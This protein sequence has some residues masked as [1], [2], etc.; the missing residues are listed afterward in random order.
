M[1]LEIKSEFVKPT[2]MRRNDGVNLSFTS[3]Q[4]FS[5]RAPSPR[6]RSPYEAPGNL[7]RTAPLCS[8]R[9]AAPENETEQQKLVRLARSIQMEI[10][11]LNS[12]VVPL[13][14]RLRKHETGMDNK[15]KKE[16][17]NREFL[18]ADLSKYETQ[19]QKAQKVVN[20]QAEFSDLV[21]MHSELQ[22]RFTRSE[23]GKLAVEL[24][25]ERR[26]WLAQIGICIEMDRKIQ[27][28]KR[29]IA[30]LMKNEDIR[31]VKEQEVQI[32]ELRAAIIENIS[33]HRR[34]KAEY[35]KLKGDEPELRERGV[36]SPGA[37]SRLKSRLQGA[38]N[39]RDNA[40]SRYREVLE[41]QRAELEQFKSE[42][43]Q[44]YERDLVQE[45]EI[46]MLK[47]QQ[48]E[49]DKSKRKT[50]PRRQVR[51]QY[52]PEMSKKTVWIGT[53]DY[54]VAM[55]TVAEMCAGC[56]TIQDVEIVRDDTALR[57]IGFAAI[58][59]FGT[60]RSA[61][62]A[63]VNLNGAWFENQ[64]LVAEWYEPLKNVY[65]VETEEDNAKKKQTSARASA[66]TIERSEKTVCE[67]EPKR[68]CRSE[69]DHGIEESKEKSEAA[70]SELVSEKHEEI[71][72]THKSDAEEEHKERVSAF[73]DD[74]FL[75][76]NASAKETRERDLSGENKENSDVEHPKLSH[77]EE[78]EKR[79]EHESGKESSK[80]S[81]SSD[82]FE[83]LDDD[84]L[85]KDEDEEKREAS[86]RNV[87]EHDKHES[88]EE[89]KDKEKSSSSSSDLKFGDLDEEF[90]DSSSS[91][92]KN[93]ENKD[94]EKLT[95]FT[96][97]MEGKSSDPEKDKEPETE[98]LKL[99]D[100]ELNLKSGEDEGE[101]KA[102]EIPEETKLSDVQMDIADAMTM[103][104]KV[105]EEEKETKET[106][107]DKE[108]K[109][110]SSSMNFDFDND[111]DSGNDKKKSSSDKKSFSGSEK[112][113][114]HKKKSSSS[115]SSDSE[116]S[117]KAE[118]KSSGGWDEDFEQKSE[119]EGKNDLKVPDVQLNVADSI[120][121][122]LDE[123]REDNEVKERTFEQMES[124]AEKSE[125]KLSSTSSSSSAEDEKQNEEKGLELS[126]IQLE[127]P[128]A[129]FSN[130]GDGE[131]KEPESDHLVR[132]RSA[133][134][135]KENSEV[136]KEEKKD[137][138]SAKGSSSSSS[139][140]HV[141]DDD[142]AEKNLEENAEKKSEAGKEDL[143]LPDVQLNVVDSFVAN[144]DEPK[145]D[146][147]V[148]ERAIEEKTPNTDGIA[149]VEQKNESEHEKKVSSSG[150]KSSSSSDSEMPVKET[151]KVE[152]DPDLKLPDIQLNVAHSVMANLEE[153]KD[154]EVNEGPHEVKD[155]GLEEEKKVS[156]TEK[157][158]EI[159]KKED[160]A[161]E[162]KP[163][164]SRK[165]SSSS[166]SSEIVTTILGSDSPKEEN[167]RPQEEV[168]TKSEPEEKND[169]KL[170]DIQL[171]IADSVVANLEE[172]K[173]DEEN[174]E[175]KSR[176]LEEEKEASEAEKQ[177][178]IEKK[179]ASDNEKKPSSSRKVS[180]SSSEDFLKADIIDSDSA[181]ENER[182]QK[183]EVITKSEPEEKNDLKLPDIQLNV[184]DSIVANF[185]KKKEEEVKSRTVEES[186]K[187]PEKDPPPKE[188]SS[189]SSDHG[190]KSSSS[191]SS[192]SEA[193][194]KES[195]V[196]SDGANKSSGGW[197]EDFDN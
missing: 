113:E 179:E 183:E 60:H 160:S 196:K 92:E 98:G 119:S 197:D 190:K 125:K 8:T 84:F 149:E 172:K 102:R 40:E 140:D 48:K 194:D 141:L 68:K 79:S 7:V 81:S 195:K 170:P 148:K 174:A 142:E 6:R 17:L 188:A 3:Y 23:I 58:V 96:L 129:M 178:E 189:K 93:E 111:F 122:N 67:P 47:E 20:K 153:K 29:R 166:S 167:E 15:Q 41:S 90:A 107:S 49:L 54:R 133:E 118:K 169:L 151:K 78:E 184:A 176:G 42:Q 177:P 168:I 94:S 154:D 64:R 157:Q 1:T 2:L 123:G 52:N 115:S 128:D 36:E 171:N 106:M 31:A 28:R 66:R 180:S 110:S 55:S 12:E 109:K 83:D 132:D 72:D 75:D 159:E 191:S 5:P 127:S 10:N 193:H 164:S 112:S 46:R 137:S 175:V 4:P 45:R 27:K 80:S 9:L 13:R 56:G 44:S 144:L 73:S 63:I 162:K 165:D 53:F 163:S 88:G 34:L 70:V 22:E 59:T 77:E 50:S 97:Q 61:E 89:H 91:E 71:E 192:D 76:S 30:Y 39:E 18:G 134:G 14:D 143:K 185:D 21:Q 147:E 33:E 74:E 181:K 108:S 85:E 131:K 121:A 99:P 182:P 117:Q 139:S 101:V 146:N 156:E 32:H 24:D 69:S 86:E 87:S 105:N 62:N 135:E 19:K 104:L 130:S 145:D 103:N 114:E 51:R 120:V 186:E 161:D 116:Q 138:S 16:T 65:P 82:N 11:S 35:A 126:E 136:A 100:L 38:N 152:S 43:M 95:P 124:P 25:T 173:E 37:L 187:A 26:K 150:N 158:P 155:R 57:A